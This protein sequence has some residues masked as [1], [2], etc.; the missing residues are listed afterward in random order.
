MV[1][2][3]GHETTPAVCG[4]RVGS[5]FTG[6]Y[7]DLLTATLLGRAE[8]SLKVALMEWE[9]VL[10]PSG[11]RPE[12]MRVFH[13]SHHQFRWGTQGARATAAPRCIHRE[14]IFS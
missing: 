1:L 13:S 12:K 5:R 8:A 11:P 10:R 3:L 6:K 2:V 4:R 9:S 14:G 7:P